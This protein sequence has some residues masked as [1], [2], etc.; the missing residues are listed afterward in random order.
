MK[1]RICF[2]VMSLSALIYYGATQLAPSGRAATVSSTFHAL[3]KTA[4]TRM[5]NAQEAD[6]EPEYQTR[7][8]NAETALEIAHRAVVSPADEREFMQLFSYIQAVKQDHVV[9]I[10]NS[11]ASLPP[12]HDA[13]NNARAAAENVFK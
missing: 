9:A 4:L 11:D 10:T 1:I 5:E 13:V 2:L 6:S 8:A 3:G 7:L 12:D